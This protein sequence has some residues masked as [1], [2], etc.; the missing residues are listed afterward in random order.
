MANTVKTIEMATLLR[1]ALAAV[2]PAGTNVYARGVPCGPDGTPDEN[3]NESIRT[4][5]M[6]DIIMIG[7][8]PQQYHSKLH[9]FVG[10]IRVVTQYDDDKFQAVLYAIADK[11]ETYLLTPPSLSLTLCNFDALVIDNQPDID[12]DDSKQYL[13]WSVT[14]N[15]R[16]TT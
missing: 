15:T 13:E 2:V 7:R 9:A 16:E 5:P 4:S 6:V 12:T 3:A 10:T 8:K 11:V 14:I 1:T